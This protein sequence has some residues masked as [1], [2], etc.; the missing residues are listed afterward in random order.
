MSFDQSRTTN[1]IWSG[2][3]FKIHYSN[4]SY[5][6]AKT[7]DNGRYHPDGYYTLAVYDYVKSVPKLS[8]CLSL[9]SFNQSCAAMS[10]NDTALTCYMSGKS[11]FISKPEEKL[12]AFMKAAH[13]E[14]LKSQ[15]FCC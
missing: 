14:T 2:M 12:N 6:S 13:S 1:L 10:Y 5:A 7:V 8:D 4:W 3:C 15:Y 9:C 11:W